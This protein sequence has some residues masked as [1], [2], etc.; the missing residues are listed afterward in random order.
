MSKTVTFLVSLLYIIGGLVTGYYAH[1][2]RIESAAAD[3]GLSVEMA[4]NFIQANHFAWGG[5]LLVFAILFHMFQLARTRRV[6]AK[7][8]EKETSLGATVEQNK[9]ELAVLKSK[10]AENTDVLTF[11]QNAIASAASK[12]E[13][14]TEVALLDKPTDYPV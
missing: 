7:H 5:G 3:A 9:A 2:F 6:N 13:A 8:I 12:P 10:M 4:T 14:G 1:A 11:C